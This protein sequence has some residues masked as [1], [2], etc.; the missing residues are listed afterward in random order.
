MDTPET[1]VEC[2]FCQLLFVPMDKKMME[3]VIAFL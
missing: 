2:A 3:M 1:Q